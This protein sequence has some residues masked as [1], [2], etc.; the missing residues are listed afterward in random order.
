MS[1]STNKWAGRAQEAEIIFG[2][3]GQAGLDFIHVTEREAWKPAFDDSGASLAALEKRYGKPAVIANGYLDDPAH[4]VEM[5]QS[6]QADMI[7][8][9]KG[10]LANHDRVNKVRNGE[11][12]AESDA[13]QVLSPD[14]KL[15]PSSVASAR[16]LRRWPCPMSKETPQH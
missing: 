4:A 13:Q 14:A 16:V 6:G 10:A 8:L 1:D 5:I 2:Q 15:K 12:L 7:A 11:P 3:L 9:G